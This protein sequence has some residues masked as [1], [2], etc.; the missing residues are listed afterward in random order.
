MSKFAKLS[1]RLNLKV[2]FKE[3][4]EAKLKGAKWD[5]VKKTWYVILTP[6]RSIIHFKKW[7]SE[8]DKAT[9]EEW[10]NIASDA[11]KIDCYNKL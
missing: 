11:D 3:K 1:F 5:K 6:D 2:S 7:L 10:M 8:K 4:E 9:V